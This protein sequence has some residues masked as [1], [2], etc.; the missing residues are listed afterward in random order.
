[1]K[2]ILK[3]TT[4]LLLSAVTL[5]CSE[6]ENPADKFLG[7]QDV[8]FIMNGETY[9]LKGGEYYQSQGELNCEITKIEHT[10]PTSELKLSLENSQVFDNFSFNFKNSFNGE[11]TSVGKTMEN[12]YFFAFTMVLPSDGDYYVGAIID[13]QNSPVFGSPDHAIEVDIVNVS[14]VINERVS[15]GNEKVVDGVR[16]D[17]PKEK[18]GGVL[19]I[20]FT[21]DDGENHNIEM[22]FKLEGDNI[23]IE[24]DNNITSG[25]GDDDNGG[26]TGGGTDC[27]NLV[28]SGPTDGQIKQF[29]QSAQ[30][31]KCLGATNELNYV[32]DVLASYN[33]SCSYCN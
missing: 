9:S 31:Y 22:D 14:L 21:D 27:D 23:V 11:E 5:S 26:G 33:A 30:L 17:Y 28:Y 16:K 4:F 6:D 1:M 25:S 8:T 24:P 13:G 15:N 18:I 32:C 12:P 10:K 2:N 29:C 19:N 3:I 7:K 20:Q